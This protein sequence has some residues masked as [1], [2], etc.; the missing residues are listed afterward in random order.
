VGARVCW[1][2]TRPAAELRSLSRLVGE[3]GGG[4][5]GGEGATASLFFLPPAGGL[6]SARPSVSVSHGPTDERERKRNGEGSEEEPTV[7]LMDG[8]VHQR[9]C[10]GM[11][12]ASGGARLRGG[13][14]LDLSAVVSSREDKVGGEFCSSW[15]GDGKV[16]AV[17]RKGYGP[18]LEKNIK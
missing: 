18:F 3:A 1:S 6:A 7:V 15:A 11:V 16:N 2:R 5:G 8:S 13:R 10:G 14:G 12:G 4:D 9:R 17:N